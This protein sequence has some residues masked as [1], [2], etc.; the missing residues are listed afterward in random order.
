[1]L[2]VASLFSQILSLCPRNEFQQAVKTHR[3]ERHSKGFSC[4]DQFVAML[5]CQ[6]GQAHSLREICGGLACSL[7][8]V[9][10]L[11]VDQAPKKSTLAYANKHRPSGLYQTVFEQLLGRCQDVAGGRKK[12]RFRH[13]LYSLDATTIDLCLSLFSWA[14]YMRTK[15]AVKLHLLLDHDG[16]LPTF[17]QITDGKTSDVAAARGLWHDRC[18]LG[19]SGRFS[20]HARRN[21]P[22]D[23]SS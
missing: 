17:A 15:G 4:W 11:G 2:R 20:L 14:R 6:L 18:P 23:F 10:H 22:A 21:R 9:R 13:K 16:Y 19:S 8:K 5:F 1:M 7:G 12:F 3:A